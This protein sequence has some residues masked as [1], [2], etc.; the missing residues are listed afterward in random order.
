MPVDIADLIKRERVITLDYDGETVEIRYK[1]HAWD[2]TIH[3][4]ILSPDTT[5]DE[6]FDI[7]VTILA[8]WNLTQARK[9]LPITRATLAALPFRLLQDISTE[10][11]R[12]LFGGEG[13]D[14][15]P[16]G[17]GPSSPS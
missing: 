8:G 2:S 15:G 4:K 10:I 1:P 11:G 14:A 17:A 13:K 16:N 12:D 6:S 9:P 7:M 5:R 3:E